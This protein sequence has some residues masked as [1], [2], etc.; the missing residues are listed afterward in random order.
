[1]VEC[2][3]PVRPFIRVGAEAVTLCLDQVGSHCFSA[4]L[5]QIGDGIAERRDGQPVHDPGGYGLSEAVLM[6]IDPGQEETVKYE[7]FRFGAVLGP[8][9]KCLGDVIEEH[10]LDDAAGPEYGCLLYTSDAADE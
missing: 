3:F 9:F 6:F 10:G 7:V 5:I 4:K 1:M 8:G 2:A